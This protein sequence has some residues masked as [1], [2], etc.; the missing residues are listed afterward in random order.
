MCGKLKSI[1]FTGNPATEL[2]DYRNHIRK[3]L[4]Q[5]ELLDGVPLSADGNFIFFKFL[6]IFYNV[7][8]IIKICRSC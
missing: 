3:I 8:I 7:L 4:P 6:I 5:L 2:P 1:T